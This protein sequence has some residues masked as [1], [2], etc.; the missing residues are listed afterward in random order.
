VSDPKTRSGAKR[1]IILSAGRAETIG[2]RENT[3]KQ[4][5]GGEKEVS[6]GNVYRVREGQSIPLLQQRRRSENLGKIKKE[7]DGAPEEGQR[8]SI[9]GEFDDHEGEIKK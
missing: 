1:K 4:S 5:L 7:M 6:V 9:L 8:R 3:R 2:R